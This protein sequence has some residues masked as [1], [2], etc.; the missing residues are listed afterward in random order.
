MHIYI[1]LT[2]KNELYKPLGW[3]LYLKATLIKKF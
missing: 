1:V 3:L 2:I